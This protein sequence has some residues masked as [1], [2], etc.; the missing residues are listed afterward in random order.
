MRGWLKAMSSG[1]DAFKNV[2]AHADELVAK[3]RSKGALCFWLVGAPVLFTKQ[4][5]HH[6]SVLRALDWNCGKILARLGF[7]Q[8][9]SPEAAPGWLLPS[10]PVSLI[11]GLMEQNPDALAKADELLDCLPKADVS[12]RGHVTR[13]AGDDAFAGQRVAVLAHWDED[14]KVD[15]YV[16]YMLRHFRSLGWKVVLT[17]A[18]SLAETEAD[19]AQL[20]DGLVCR[21]CPGYDFTSWKAALECFPSLMEAKELIFCNDSVF[22]AIGSY[23]PMHEVMDGIPCDFWGISESREFLP[24][25]QS[26]HLVFGEKVLRHPAFTAFMR[27]VPLSGNRTEAVELETCFSLWLA[28]HGLQPAVFMPV[29]SSIPDLANP[30]C[31]C[32]K[33]LVEAGV[34]LIKRELIFRNHRKVDLSGWVE[35]LKERD[36]PIEL[37]LR[38][39]WRKKLDLTPLLCSGVRSGHWPPDVLALQHCIDLDAVNPEALSADRPP[40][41]VF[42]HVFYPHLLPEIA[43]YIQNLPRTAHIHVSTDTEDKADAVRAALEPLGFARLVVRVLP[44]KGWDI[45]PFIVGFADEIRSYPIIVRIHAKCSA[46]LPQETADQWRAMLFSSLLGSVD[47]V[48]RLEALFSWDTRLGMICPPPVAWY[49]ANVNPAGN[50]GAMNRLLAPSGITLAP[51]TAIDFPMG[52]MFWCRSEVLEPWLKQQLTFED[53]DFSDAQQR[54]GSLAHALERVFLFGCG[55]AGLRW[56]RVAPAEFGGL[57]PVPAAMGC[58]CPPAPRAEGVPY[59][60]Y[61]S[62]F[63]RSLKPRLKERLKRIPFVVTLWHKFKRK[64]ATIAGPVVHS[65]LQSGLKLGADAIIQNATGKPELVVI[66]PRIHPRNF[67]GGPNTALLFAAEVAKHGYGVHCL[68]E[69]PPT[70]STDVLRTHLQELLSV[71]QSVAQ[72]FRVSCMSSRVT[73]NTND[74]LLATAW[75][76]VQTAE[77]L[78]QRMDK[79]RFFYFIQDFEPLFYPW[80]EQH[81]GAMLSYEADFLPIFNES[82]LADFC[83]HVQ[84]GRF[85]DETFRK[86]SLVFTPA[87]DRTQF[88]PEKQRGKHQLLFYARP[89]A[90]R[91]LYHF[92]MEAMYQLVQEN[93]ITADKWDI[94]CMG[95]DTVPA[96]VLGNDV[97]TQTAPWLGFGDYAGRIRQASVGLSLML[98]PHTSY[99]PLELAAAGVPVVTTSYVNKTPEMLCGLSPDIIGVAPTVEAITDGLRRAV[100]R[101]E[102]TAERTDALAAPGTWLEAFD[103]I[104][105]RVLKFMETGE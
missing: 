33:A 81:A 21:T 103:P 90:P 72:N 99:M 97:I 102:S 51:H 10:G 68:S 93:I 28:R 48:Q 44:N 4:I 2:Y 91:N 1:R 23:A 5:R 62:T 65:P 74:R 15:E 14:R 34:P 82:C 38:Y 11:P 70:C 69:S 22:G 96:T 46:Q 79:R 52:S 67:S 83:F 64:Q 57:V 71:E 87:V 56:G 78:A 50:I 76:T 105:P 25:I 80:N 37:I 20:V 88:H 30:S 31:D 39:G 75:W 8:H 58:A 7:I 17:S 13:L 100:A 16:R 92:G 6:R 61:A 55:I 32:W 66:L 104:M 73:L 63:V 43:S 47:R 26:F 19:V 49:A 95:D 54:D 40:L 84:P 36:Y 59:Q 27:R 98:S 35:L 42:I 12:I 29:A 86:E 77:T 89:T 9:C 94:V 85:A 41:G 18:D 53:F 3:A 24:H 101:A 60:A 45:A